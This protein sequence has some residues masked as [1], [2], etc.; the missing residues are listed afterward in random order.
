VLNLVLTTVVLGIVIGSVR[1]GALERLLCLRLRLKWVAVGCWLLQVALFL[2]AQGPLP[3]AWIAALHLASALLVGVVILANR[4]L[5]GFPIIGLGLA[6]NFTVYVVNGGFMPV[7]ESALEA[8]GRAQA[9]DMYEGGRFQKTFLM[10]PDSQ[11]SFLGDV[12]PVRVIG[13]VYSPGDLLAA[14]GVCVLVASSMGTERQRT[15][16]ASAAPRR[17]TAG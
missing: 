15:G 9:T 4:R 16:V 8:S 7:S 10:Q 1:G 11:L 12:I 14:L 13:K 3:E 5:A 2:P 6:L 17:T